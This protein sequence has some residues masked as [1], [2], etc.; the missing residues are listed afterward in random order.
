MKNMGF[1]MDLKIEVV[2]KIQSGIITN[3]NYVVLYHST[4]GSTNLSSLAW[5]HF[6]VTNLDL[7]LLKRHIKGY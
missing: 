6:C 5:G 2:F 1:F 3:T 4:M 7:K